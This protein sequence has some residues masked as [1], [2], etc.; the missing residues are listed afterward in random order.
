[1]LVM[2]FGGT[3]VADA[4]AI[5]HVVGIVERAKASSGAPPVVVVSAMSGV[6]DALLALA[7]SAERRLEPDAAV[8]ALW[9]RHLATLRE[10]VPPERARGV[11]Q[12]LAVHRDELDALLRSAAILRGAPPAARDAIAAMGELMNSR[13]VAAALDAAGVPASWVDAR[14]VVV[15]EPRHGAAPPL[16]AETAA[17]AARAIRPV[18]ADGRVPVVGGFVGATIEGVTTTLGRGGSDF[19]AS[20]VG[21]AL[22]ASEI[23]IWTDVD[24]MLT[25]DPRVVEAARIVPQLSFD[26]ASEL[27]YFG[28]K[29]LHPST[30]LPAVTRG[31]PVRILNTR[32]ADAAGTL[33]TRDGGGEARPLAAVACK[34]GIT[35][36]EITSTRM[37]MTYGFLRRVFEAFERFRTAVDVVTTSEVSVSVTVDDAAQVE[38]IAGALGEIADVRVEGG[39]AIVSAVGDRLRADTRVAARVIGALQEFP[40]R[41]VSQAAS[42]RNVTIVLHD[43]DAARAMGR[44]HEEFFGD[45]GT[46]PGPRPNG[47]A[48][49]VALS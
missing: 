9:Q 44:L 13:I 18:L 42:R 8:E 19:S 46:A 22:E 12:A 40:V 41:M 35:M 33:I 34:R 7:V 21:A 28:A 31:I 24:G 15:T 2:K 1:M 20:I 26:E 4:P 36:I 45:A 38:A 11:R 5:A 29:V 47:P 32:R 14:D 25:A 17:A 3:S 37:L 27:A 39:M 49:R 6:T 30:I 48:G 16:A 43:A 10:L 23:Q